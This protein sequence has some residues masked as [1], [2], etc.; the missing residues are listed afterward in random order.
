MDS[1]SMYGCNE[2]ITAPVL[3]SVP[4]LQLSWAQTTFPILRHN[5]SLKLSVAA[6]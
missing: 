4:Q 1:S 3:D 6:F 2:P 5:T